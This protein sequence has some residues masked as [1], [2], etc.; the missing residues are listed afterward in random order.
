MGLDV[1]KEQ[2]SGRDGPAL[3][4]SLSILLF[5]G[6]CHALT[7]EGL[8]SLISLHSLVA[9][10]EPLWTDDFLLKPVPDQLI[11]SLPQR[12]F[13]QPECFTPLCFNGRQS[14]I[15]PQPTFSQVRQAT[16]S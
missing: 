14:F 8:G 12:T 7:E 16:L 13:Q 3:P 10:A 9:G 1:I 4:D 2:Q 6:T 11:R 15:F 5:S